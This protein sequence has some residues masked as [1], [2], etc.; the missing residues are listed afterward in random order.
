MARKYT[1]IPTRTYTTGR[2]THESVTT[3]CAALLEEAC[4]AIEA[5][6]VFSDVQAELA[7]EGGTGGLVRALQVVGPPG[8]LRP[9]GRGGGGDEG[10]RR[11]AHP[12]ALPRLPPP[13]GGRGGGGG[14]GGGAS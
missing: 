14:G 3:K 4:A 8:L 2:R 13:A 12:G 10:V 6:A 1:M 7:G 5:L 11:G 9:R